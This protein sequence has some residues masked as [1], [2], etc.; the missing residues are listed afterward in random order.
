MSDLVSVQTIV[1]GYVQGVSFRDF[2]LRWAKE[3]GVVG[4]VRNLP[5]RTTVEIQAK[6]ERK[7]LEKL[8]EQLRLGPPGAE[9]EK[10]KI[11]WH[12]HN[13]SYSRFSIRY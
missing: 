5:D 2:T 11:S 4:Y 13:D 12:T 7:K 3:L 10:V 8:I 1:Y 6:G 9:V